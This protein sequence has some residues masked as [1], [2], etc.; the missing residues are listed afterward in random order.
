MFTDF[1]FHMPTGRIALCR[2]RE[3]IHDIVVTDIASGEQCSTVSQQFLPQTPRFSPDGK[4]LTCAGNGRIHLHSIETGV[5]ETIVDLPDHHAGFASWSSDGRSLAFSAYAVPV[6]RDSPPRIFRVGVADDAI[7]EL[8]S[9]HKQYVDRF[10]QWSASGAKLAFRRTFYEALEPYDAIVLADSELRSQRQV[11]LPDGNSHHASRFCWSP[12]DRHLLIAETGKTTRLK[13]FD[14]TD[15]S[16]IW[17]VD[18]DEP[19]HGCFDPN[20]RQVL[21]VYKEALRLFAPPSTE[22]I[23]DLSLA[24]LSPIQVTP[25]GPAVAFDRNGK[26]IY[27]LGTDGVLYRWEIGG[28]CE[29]LMRDQA[30]KVAPPH[31]RR[32]Y[33]FKARDG[34]DIPVQRYLS[35]NPNGRAIVYVDGGPSGKIGEDDPVVLSLVEEGYE[36]I[37]PAYRGK[38]GYGTV[39]EL[40]NRGECGRA[41]VLD[42]VDCGLDWRRR[43][44]ADDRPLAVSGFSYGGFLT[45]LALT[46]AEAQWS[47]GI[48]L[49]G[50]TELMAPW[51]SRGLPVDPVERESALQERSPVR[52]AGDIQFPLLIL[53]GGRDTT[54]TTHEVQSIQKSDRESGSYCELVV[55]EEDTHGLM[56][57]RP[58]MLS[59]MLEFL[60]TYS[61]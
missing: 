1:D 16:L 28:A 20:G 7:V 21:G 31:E 17:T 41:D 30:Q 8:K 49:W 22:P 59:R 11:P 25:T 18:A 14:V 3:W 35:K 13:V 12:D 10:P 24:S 9:G 48:T 34:L 36:V 26:G 40:A 53:H 19:V 15:L 50:V 2:D 23:A 44:D 57:S 61:Q 29:L 45:F 6:S 39:H 54:A 38:S 32:D 42:V 43:F 47:C 27:F 46:H 55:F 4:L 37:R 58:E 51:H 56:L 5:T 52:R 33:R 60:S